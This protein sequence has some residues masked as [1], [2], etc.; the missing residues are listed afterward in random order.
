MSKS[1][2]RKTRLAGRTNDVSDASP[3]ITTVRHQ[4]ANASASSFDTDG[5]K[6]WTD[7]LRMLEVE[8]RVKKGCSNAIISKENRHSRL[9]VSSFAMDLFDEPPLDPR[10]SKVD[11]IY[12]WDRFAYGNC[13]RPERNDI[14]YRHECCHT[15]GNWQW[16]NVHTKKC[17]HGVKVARIDD[18]CNH[19]PRSK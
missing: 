1:L 9:R 3:N 17:C 15:G 18:T 19:H 5:L 11:S 10:F 16:Y 7:T 4:W 14:P 2:P 6:A 13:Q 8:T 12:G